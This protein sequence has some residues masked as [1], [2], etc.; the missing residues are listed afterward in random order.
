MLAGILGMFLVH[1]KGAEAVH[2]SGAAPHGPS[3]STG[4]GA[5]AGAQG[6]LPGGAGTP[7]TQPSPSLQ[8]FCACSRGLPV[9]L[10]R[11]ANS[12]ICL[13]GGGECIQN[14]LTS[15]LFV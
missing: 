3:C 2:C 9:K 6:V 14:V 4:L 8:R 15:T 5:P 13:G 11:A 12:L 10:D 1:P 7:C